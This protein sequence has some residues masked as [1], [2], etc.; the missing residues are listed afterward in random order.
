MV[1]ATRIA[2]PDR[3][4]GPGACG[5]PSTAALSG[6]GARPPGRAWR[7]AAPADQ[8]IGAVELILAELTEQ[9]FLAELG[10]DR[11]STEL[12]HDR[13]PRCGGWNPKA[14]QPEM[15]TPKENE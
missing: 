13:R 15:T 12:L 1:R 7:A 10:S 4:A 8:G 2:V 5:R 3:G 6:N 11:F 9:P 14:G